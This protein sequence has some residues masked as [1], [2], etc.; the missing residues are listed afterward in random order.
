MIA[1]VGQMILHLCELWASQFA[2]VREEVNL[3]C[4]Y[5]NSGGADQRNSEMPETLEE[6]INFYPSSLAI[7]I[8]CH[9]MLTRS[10]ASREPSI[11]TGAT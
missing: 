11:C 10:A 4:T 1:L 9:Q 5:A 8:V 2:L 7:T 6:S 3:L